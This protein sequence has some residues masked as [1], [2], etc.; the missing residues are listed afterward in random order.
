VT[1][2]EKLEM[3]E[4]LKQIIN[5]NYE[6]AEKTYG[7]ESIHFLFYVSQTLTN[8]VALGEIE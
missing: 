4:T 6:I 5:K 7:K 8:K 2:A 1:A 3:K